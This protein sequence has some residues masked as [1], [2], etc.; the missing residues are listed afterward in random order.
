MAQETST[1]PA[2]PFAPS[3]YEFFMLGLCFLAIGSLAVDVTVNLTSDG[4]QILRW[5]DNALCGIFFL[6]FLISL[7]RAPDR[8]RYLRT[9]GWIDFASSIPAFDLLRVG[10]GAR[11]I[12]ILR[13]LRGVRA[14]KL[15]ATFVL[16]RR[17]QGTAVAAAL[18]S[19]LLLFFS[20]VSVLHFEDVEG[21]NIKGAEDALWWAFVTI[22]T[23][24]YGDRFPVSTEGRMIGAMLMLAGVGLFGT[25]SG[26]VA[27]WFLAPD[28]E[29]QESELAR[30]TAEVAA[31]REEVVRAA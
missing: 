27:A 30:L 24:G 18:V 2:V 9:W 6:D 7:A 19:L 17:A 25:L 1:L 26:F 14:T 15:L 10:R 12:R 3:L 31:L 21:A 13:V 16:D 11:V 5:A 22:T 28:A 8:W 20:A 4:R 29:K 23:V